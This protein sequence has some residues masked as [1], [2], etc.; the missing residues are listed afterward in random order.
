VFKAFGLV[1]VILVIV[2]AVAWV[3]A[4]FLGP[5]MQS[6]TVIGTPVTPAPTIRPSP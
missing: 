2:V 6:G 3:G 4:A 1:L 5:T